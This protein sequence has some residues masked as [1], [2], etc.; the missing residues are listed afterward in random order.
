MDLTALS[1][2]TLISI[3]HDLQRKL[4]HSEWT[5]MTVDLFISDTHI[6]IANT[7]K[8]LFSKGLWVGNYLNADLELEAD[9]IQ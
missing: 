1:N 5:E 4:D 9:G 8:I 6:E 3:I 2:D 7:R